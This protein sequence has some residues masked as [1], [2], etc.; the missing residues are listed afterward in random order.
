M[1][2]HR[3]DHD[4]E[5]DVLVFDEFFPQLV[6]R[7]LVDDD[8]TDQKM[9]TPMRAYIVEPRTTSGLSQSRVMVCL[10]FF[11][12]EGHCCVLGRAPGRSQAGLSLLAGQSGKKRRPLG[13]R[14]GSPAFSEARSGEGFIYAHRHRCCSR[15]SCRRSC[16]CSRT[17]M[18]GQAAA[19]LLVL[20][21]ELAKAVFVALAA[22][23]R[24][25]AHHEHKQQQ[26]QQAHDDDGEEAG[27]ALAEGVGVALQRGR[28]LLG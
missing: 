7:D 23:A 9:T 15:P 8:K 6:G 17:P 25:G 11:A 2:R 5:G 4:G 28:G 18:S 16:R 14:S 26:D 19:A 20:V 1:D 24:D 13:D 27:A 10:P 3:A 21:A 12:D 22:V